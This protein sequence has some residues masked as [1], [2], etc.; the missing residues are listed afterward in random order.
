MFDFGD[1]DDLSFDDITA[2]TPPELFEFYDEL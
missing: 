2:D 1:V